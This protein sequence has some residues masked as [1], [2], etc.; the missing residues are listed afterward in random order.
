MQTPSVDAPPTGPADRLARTLRWARWLVLAIWLALV[1]VL[2]PLSDSLGGKTNDTAQANLPAKAAS[3]KVAEIQ[4]AATKGRPKTDQADVVLVRAAGLSAADS[5]AVTRARAA[6]ADLV[7][8][9]PHLAKPDGVVA[10]KDGKAALFSVDVNALTKDQSDADGDAVKAIRKAVAGPVKEAGDGLEVKVT[11][12]AA[13]SADGGIGDQNTLLLISLSIVVVV[14]LLVYRSPVL[15]IFPLIGTIASLIAAKAMT[16]GLASAGFTVTSISTAI[17]TVLVLGT[18]TDYALLLVHRYRE[19]L[20]ARPTPVEAMA[21]ALR[22]T[23]PSVAA[24]AATVVCGML[25]L[26][27]AQSAALRGLGPVAAVAIA[28]VLVGQVTLLPALLLLVGRPGFWPLVPRP[29]EGH[30]EGSRAWRSIGQWVARRPVPVA[31]GAVVLLGAACTGLAS[32]HTSNDPVAIVKGQKDSVVGRH[33]VV[34]HFPAGATDPL[35]VLSPPDEAAKVASVASGTPQVAAV[36]AADPVGRY[37]ATDVTL[38]VPPYGSQGYDVLKDLRGRLDAQAPGALVGGGPAVQYDTAQAADRDAKVLIPLVLVVVLIIIS[39]LVR[40]LV[41]PVVLVLTTALSFAAAF[42]L[43]SLLW[44]A[45]G[46][47]GIEAQLPLYIFVF[48]IALGVDYNIF[49]I[50]RVREEART[51]G[52]HEGMLRGLSV[53]GGVITAAGVVLA[54]TFGALSRLP[55]VPV[56]QVGSAIA[57]GVLLD[58]LLVRTVLVPA[59][60]LALGERS[61]WPSTSAGRARGADR[62]APSSAADLGQGAG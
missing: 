58:T 27:A 51:L 3:T 21:V 55:Y 46:Y 52:I 22:R 32:L 30:E 1:V 60:L 4:D 10:S 9:V 26:L 44:H 8:K 40:A 34:A 48:L 25:C 31:I 15:W 19:E 35:T 54:S 18:S 43:A 62:T 28:A 16:S 24:S 61:W 6:V 41:A 47:P 37:S 20:R 39:I 50:G 2:N 59:G 56:A 38:S 5:A 57:V 33:L 45:L 7:G 36:Q 14:L 11:G 17:L 13:L 42:G 49:L 53:T 29:T 12:A 23:L